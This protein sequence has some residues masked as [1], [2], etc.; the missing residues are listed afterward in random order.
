M[1]LHAA[2]LC[3]EKRLNQFPC[4]RKGNHPSAETNDVHI[5]VFHPLVG[6]KDVVN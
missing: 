1:S 5:V 3:M 6:G 4:R 2:E